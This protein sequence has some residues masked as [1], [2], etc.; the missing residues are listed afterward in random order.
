MHS[1]AIPLAVTAVLVTGAAVPADAQQ[2]IVYPAK[3]QSPQQQQRVDGLSLE[4]VLEVTDLL[5][6]RCELVLVPLERGDG[7]PQLRLDALRWRALAKTWRGLH[8]GGA[9]AGGFERR[10]DRDGTL[11]PWWIRSTIDTRRR[12]SA[13]LVDWS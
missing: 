11:T 6:T 7:R 2:V 10:P 8:P 3:G 5:Q 12:R 1:H 13:F 9:V 4:A